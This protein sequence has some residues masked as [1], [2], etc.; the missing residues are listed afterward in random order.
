MQ[1]QVQRRQKS[2]KEKRSF[3][4]SHAEMQRRKCIELFF[5]YHCF[6]PYSRPGEIK[7][8]GPDA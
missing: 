1:M 8:F 2:R 3:F 7:H 4:F 6:R 5:C